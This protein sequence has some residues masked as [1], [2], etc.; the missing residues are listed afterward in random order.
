[1]TYIVHWTDHRWRPQLPLGRSMAV[2]PCRQII[3]VEAARLPAAQI[4]STSELHMQIYPYKRGTAILMLYIIFAILWPPF[5]YHSCWN[6]RSLDY[7]RALRMRCK[8]GWNKLWNRHD[9]F[10]NSRETCKISEH[11]KRVGSKLP[12]EFLHL[13]NIFSSVL[14]ASWFY[15]FESFKHANFGWQQL[16]AGPGC[17]PLNC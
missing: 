3:P 6:Y 16:F 11:F 5:S 13:L 17:H 7:E 8:H 9:N 12:R 15:T 10:G 14:N 4:I 1:M 2:C